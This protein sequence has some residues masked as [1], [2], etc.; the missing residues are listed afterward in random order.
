MVVPLETLAWAALI[1]FGAYAV[2]GLAG[3]GSAITATPLLAQ[4]MPLHSAVPMMLLLDTCS[5]LYLGSRNRRIVQG[6]ELLRL[7]P[8]AVIGIVLG[9]TVLVHAPERWLLLALGLFVA[10]YAGW[11]LLVRPGPVRQIASA[12]AAPVGT[13]GGVFTA[14]FGVGGPIYTLYLA[15]RIHDK[16]A[17]RATMST[18]VLMTACI[19]LPMF[20]IAG[21]YANGQ[22]LHMALWLLP[23]AFAGMVLGSHVHSRLPTERI[24]QALWVLLLVSGAGL[25]WRHA[26]A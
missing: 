16:Q 2:F 7:L 3:F 22:A 5:S 17:L 9:V 15:G 10:G 11:K 1:V 18:M 6:R 20:V 23:C 24:T 14:L 21:L 26:L 12:W 25:I 13:A 4:I 8:F 19:R